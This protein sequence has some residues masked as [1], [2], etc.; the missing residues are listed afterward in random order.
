MHDSQIKI[1]HISFPLEATASL[2]VTEWKGICTQLI[3]AIHKR[4][5]G[6]NTSWNINPTMYL[7]DQLK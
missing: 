7:A 5:P 2:A 4:L 3:Q 1:G 6:L